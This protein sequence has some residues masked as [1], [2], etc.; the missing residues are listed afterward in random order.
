MSRVDHWAGIRDKSVSPLPSG[1]FTPPKV[2]PELDELHQ[3]LIDK[4]AYIERLCAEIEAMVEPMGPF[5]GMRIARSVAKAHG[6]TFK[7]MTSNRRQK[8]LV[9]AR[10]HAM[11]EMRRHTKLSLPQIARI[12]GKLDHTTVLWGISQHEKRLLGEIA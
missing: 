7:A 6:L 10:H 3:R 11:W 4:E 8:N 5:A 12:L 9:R 2:V 1:K